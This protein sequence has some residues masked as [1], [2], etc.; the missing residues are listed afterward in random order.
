MLPK[1]SDRPKKGGKRLEALERVKLNEVES[2][3]RFLKY[4]IMY[5][6]GGVEESF[7]ALIQPEE[8][9]QLK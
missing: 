4:N 1:G 7:A 2:F 6:R 5:R 3:G 8:G 9:E